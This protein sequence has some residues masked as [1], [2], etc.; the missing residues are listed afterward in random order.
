MSV[1]AE[2]ELA[3]LNARSEENLTIDRSVGDRTYMLV[4]S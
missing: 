1:D 3:V 2:M 4:V